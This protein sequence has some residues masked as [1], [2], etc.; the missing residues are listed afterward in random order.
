MKRIFQE[1]FPFLLQQKIRNLRYFIFNIWMPIHKIEK[2][3]LKVIHIGQ[4]SIG[5]D[6][7]QLLYGENFIRKKIG[8]VFIWNTISYIR[9]MK[10]DCDLIL[11]GNSNYMPLKEV[12]KQ[13]LI[14]PFFVRQIV[15]IPVI[16]EDLSSFF[17]KKEVW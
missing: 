1:Y 5:P 13:M 4:V 3:G 14:L 17:L 2:N 8:H 15:N 16:S 9:Y 6:I 10:N 7:E 12:K 11:F